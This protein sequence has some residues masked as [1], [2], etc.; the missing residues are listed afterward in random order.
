MKH[1]WQFEIPTAEQATAWLVAMRD[2]HTDQDALLLVRETR[3]EELTMATRRKKT[4][5]CPECRN[6]MDADCAREFGCCASC[7]DRRLGAA[8]REMED[9]EYPGLYD[10][11]DERGTCT[12]CGG[13]GWD[14][15]CDWEGCYCLAG[16]PCG[17]CGGSG[18]AKDQRIW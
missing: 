14:Y 13:D 18:L 16:H 12:H 4:L 5:R 3:A 15:E 9:D 2:N 8:M 10:D 6:R 1:R 11:D 7:R 17:A